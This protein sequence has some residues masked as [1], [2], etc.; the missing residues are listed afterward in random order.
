MDIGTLTTVYDARDE[1]Q[2]VANQ[3]LGRE[4]AVTQEVVAQQEKR[5]VAAEAASAREIAGHNAAATAAEEAAARA[6]AAAES[7]RRLPLDPFPNHPQPTHPD[8]VDPLSGLTV[9]QQQ[10]A[11]QSLQ[12]QRSAA[13]LQTW[14]TDEA[15]RKRAAKEAEAETLRLTKAAEAERV[16]AVKAAEK[17]IEQTLTKGVAARQSILG[18]LANA[19]GTGGLL[20]RFQGA[21][22]VADELKSLEAAETQAASGA[23]GLLAALVAVPT[24]LAAAVAAAAALGVVIIGMAVHASEAGSKLHDLSA[25]TNVSVETLGTLQYAAKLS[26]SSLE[27]ITGS[28]IIFNRN[29]EAARN[30]TGAARQK[31]RELNVDLSD[32]EA[33]FNAVLQRL[34]ELPAGS[35]RSAE[36]MKFFGRSGAEV[37]KLLEETGGS[38]DKLRAKLERNG[39]LISTEQADAAD[40]FGDSIDRLKGRLEAVTIQ[41]GLR[42]IPTLQK[43]LD[44]LDTHAEAAQQQIG[45]L[46]LGISGLSTLMEVEQAKFKVLV[47]TIEAFFA[48]QLAL[49]NGLRDLFGDVNVPAPKIP[50]PKPVP[51]PTADTPERAAQETVQVV[52]H[53]VADAERR[54][55]EVQAEVQRLR[56]AGETAPAEL[57]QRQIDA[58]AA[59][60]QKRITLINAQ[61]NAAKLKR[62]ALEPSEDTAD[63]IQAANGEIQKLEE[64]ATDEQQ[65]NAQQ[66]QETLRQAGEEERRIRRDQAAATVRLITAESTSVTAADTALNEAR[67]KEGLRG[68]EGYNARRI[69]I[70]KARYAEETRAL[71]LE[72]SST[73]LIQDA[74]EQERTRADVQ[75]REREALRRHETAKAQIEQDG[76]ERR[77]QIDRQAA[78]EQ[79]RLSEQTDNLDLTRLRRRLREGNVT[80]EEYDKAQTDRH[81]AA[82][83]SRVQLENR[84]V[85]TLL[86]QADMLPP[87]PQGLDPAVL[88]E[89]FLNNTF[90][91]PDIDEDKMDAAKQKLQAALNDYQT[92]VEE[93]TDSAADSRRKDVEDATQWASQMYEIHR[94]VS[95]AALDS[96]QSQVNALRGFPGAQDEVRDA[97]RLLDIRREQVRFLD[98]WTEANDRLHRAGLTENPQR[99]EDLQAGIN[100]EIESMERQHT[101]KMLEIDR[102][103]FDALREEQLQKVEQIYGMLTNALDNFRGDWGDLWRDLLNEALQAVRQIAN[104]LIHMGLEGLATGE[105]RGSSAPGLVGSIANAAGQR[106]FGHLLNTGRNV[107]TA[108]MAAHNQVIDAGRQTGGFTF[109]DPFKSSGTEPVV[110][111]TNASAEK[112]S[113]AVH[114]EGGNT[115]TALHDLYQ[116]LTSGPTGPGL[117]GQALL[118]FLSS[119]GGQFGAHLA[120]S[121][122]APRGGEH[123][124]EPVTA[125]PIERRAGGGMTEGMT[126]LGEFG[127]ELAYFD[128]PTQIVNNRDTR[129]LLGGRTENNYYYIQQPASRARSYTQKRAQREGAEMVSNIIKTRT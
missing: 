66:R 51:L 63:K 59:A 99:R 43:G 94:R 39:A 65:K 20:N 4:R 127:P 129:N 11:E 120:S 108:T 71:A 115:V 46:G 48:P 29:L 53:E 56:A 100:R 81:L 110:N 55:R 18:K 85:V 95:N 75:Q 47:G 122:S 123:P 33:A 117:A 25:K 61:I 27:S 54:L 42:F 12:R 89:R 28:I 17:E 15:E 79:I 6:R 107:P 49:I 7:T 40:A 109:Y 31:F 60:S 119:V 90:I 72:F 74:R 82:L 44:M 8:A 121:T 111:A 118:A 32:N 38:L 19:T 106:L 23:S 37:L 78:E 67:Y 41:I 10:S 2:A 87:I 124:Y 113:A 80:N 14:R 126:L 88:A 98:E 76:R 34:S 26:G 96:Q 62:D 114:E 92:A 52:Q 50:D 112:V 9:R 1:G 36:A 16:K 22:Q 97:Q 77:R 103:Y 3:V 73:D 116:A 91:S 128:R 102:A 125:H 58:E 83:R 57:A 105:T 84:E 5:A 45:L 35:Q 93:A 86:K 70:E 69:A 64:Q 68:L 21:E 104:E 13:L 101:D 30:G 24:A